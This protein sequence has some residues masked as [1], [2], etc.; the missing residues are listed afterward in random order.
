M[1]QRPSSAERTPMRAGV[2]FGPFRLT[3]DPLQLWRG[4]KIV[5]LQR[6]PLSVLRY[7]VEHPQTV[8]SSDTLRQAIW[9]G[10]VVSTTALQ[11]CI[12][13]VRKALGD[14]TN[15]P[16]YIETVGREGYRFIAPLAATPSPVSGSKFPVSDL[17]IAQQETRNEKPETPLVGREAELAQLHTLLEKA[18]HGER[19][20]AFITGEA[21]I[22]KTTLVDT[23]LSGIRDWGLWIGRGQCLEHYGEGEAYLP[24]L[25]A[26]TQLC[27]G[28]EGAECLSAL[29]RYAPTWVLHL[30]GVID[31]AE[32]AL[33]QQRGAGALQGQMLREMAEALESMSAARGVVLV[34]ED[35]HVSDPSTVELLAYLAQRR[36]PA[37]LF[38]V[39]TYRPVEV[40]VNDHPLRGRVQ[41]FLARGLGNRLT[42]E[43]FTEVEVDAYLRRRLSA[44]ALPATLAQQI[45]QRT[46][47]NP[48]FVVNTVE[49]LLQRE[50]LAAHAGQWRLTRALSAHEIPETLQYLIGKQ[51]DDLP[52]EQQR[53]LEVASI[54]GSVFTTASVAAGMQTSVESVEEICEGLAQRGQFIVDRGLMQWPDGTVSGQYGFR[55][56]LYPEVLSQRLGPG[57]QARMHRV[58]GEREEQAYGERVNEVAAELAQHFVQGQDAPRAIRYLLAAGHNGMQRAACVEAFSLFSQALSLLE[59]QAETPERRVQELEIRLGLTT[60]LMLTKGFATPEVEQ[61]LIRAQTL[62]QQVGETPELCVVLTGFWG[63]FFVRGEMRVARQWA[64]RALQA[65]QGEADPAWRGV[66]QANMQVTLYHQGELTT[67][68]LYGEQAL[69]SFANAPTIPV[70]FNHVADPW[71][72][73]Q[74]YGAVILHALGYLD[75]ALRQ[76]HVVLAQMRERQQAQILIS[77]LLFAANVHA[78]CREWGEVQK[79]AA[80][81]IELAL[82]HSLSF[83][84]AMGTCIH[85]VALTQQD[86]LTEGIDEI[87]RGVAFYRATGASSG[88]P[89]FLGW[90]AEAYGRAG[91]IDEGLALIAEAFALIE[92]DG[93]QLWEGELYRRKGE[94]TLQKA[95]N[96][97]GSKFQDPNAQLLAPSTQVNVEA[98]AYFLKAIAITQQQQAK[99]FE[100][101]ATTS[102]ARL[103][104]Q[105]GK[106]KEA[107]QMLAKCYGW[108]TEGFGTADLREAKA[109]LDELV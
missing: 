42:L 105:Q 92:R 74:G 81:L 67:A 91:R 97:Q 109:L 72:R 59:K 56:A 20:L 30:P 73:S 95:F 13:E 100:L 54:V 88:M 77:V 61:A 15:T 108:F 43:L 40:V 98:E 44:A 37:Q 38:L 57:R 24:V 87:T 106:I 101:R 23:F 80:E 48:L 7:F 68:C 47:G 69:T 60:A 99:L 84:W 19:Q 16:R 62:C 75:Q 46:D 1:R 64:E 78:G 70:L 11:V 14:E 26:I 103:W 45:G 93:E 83:W 102:L 65:S 21:G 50:L 39:G 4:R 31:Q 55:H 94:L 85:G 12:R 66:A 9:G 71:V 28:P 8:I 29:Q 49:Y 22:G 86:Q 96:V 63:V 3:D 32:H 10:T 82:A 90:L 107:H 53:M 51:L 35:L 6:R 76:I 79:F 58:I 18:L 27:R 34:L 5:P 33:L 89:R 41:E 36:A 25:E 2:H 17:N 104:R 52:L